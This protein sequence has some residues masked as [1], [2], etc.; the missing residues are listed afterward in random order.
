MREP[1]VRLARRRIMKLLALALL[2]VVS[3]AACGDDGAGAPTDGMR[4]ITWTTSELVT[5]GV[6]ASMPNGVRL[7]LTL[8]TDD[9]LAARAGCNSMSGTYRI[10]DGRLVVTDLG[11]T[12]MGCDPDR[13]ANDA[14]IATLLS[15]RPAIALYGG[16]LTVAGATT[17]LRLVDLET[18]DPASPLIGTTW[19]LDTLIDGQSASTIPQE[20]QG[21]ATLSFDTERIAWTSGC[22]G[23]GGTYQMDRGVLT[24]ADVATTLIGCPE[25]VKT[26]EATMAAVLEAKPKVVLVRHRLTVTAPNGKGLGFTA[27]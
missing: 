18:V 16:T 6:A 1:V 25:P 17:A 21:K 19:L 13:M 12:E 10:R 5:N 15:S 3:L 23:S 14:A 9:R 27:R 11:Q 22:N 20:L 8:G 24:L 2:A 7:E 4:G 26:V